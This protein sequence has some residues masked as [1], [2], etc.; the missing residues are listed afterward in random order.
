MVKGNSHACMFLCGWFA[1]NII[2]C[3]A[4]ALALA[5]AAAASQ[6][7]NFYGKINITSKKVNE[8]KTKHR[9]KYSHKGTIS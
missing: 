4:I 3:C 7:L 9:H 6:S 1:N 8:I 2:E 5:A